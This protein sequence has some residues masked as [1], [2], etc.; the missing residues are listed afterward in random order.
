[1]IFLLVYA[2]NITVTGNPKMVDNLITLH[3]FLVIEAC[4]DS[5]G[6]YLSQPEYRRC[7]LK[8][9]QMDQAK[10]YTILVDPSQTLSKEGAKPMVD[11]ALYRII[12]KAL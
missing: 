2:D 11:Y 1:M 5:T 8:K 10:P 9:T 6:L 7:L 12:V 3:Y 4:N